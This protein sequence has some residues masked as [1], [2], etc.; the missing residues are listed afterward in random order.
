MA[1]PRSEGYRAGMRFRAELY[2][3]AGDAA[4]YFLT[5]PVEV[6]EPLRESVV[7]PRRGFGAVKV[8]VTVGATTWATSVFPQKEGTYVLPV[9]KSVRTAEGLDDGD[10]VTVELDPVD[11]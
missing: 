6:A 10:L 2:R 11:P 9:K 7:S 8:R 5:V 1:S 3:Y 4:W